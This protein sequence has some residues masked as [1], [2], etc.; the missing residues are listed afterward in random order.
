MKVA[1]LGLG[2]MGAHMARNLA[3][4][5]HDVTVWN[6]TPS[7]AEQLRDHGA[8]VAPSIAQAVPQ[9]DI[10]V[11]MLAD[12]AAVSS[13]AFGADGIICHLKTGAIH[14]SMSTISVALSQQLAAEHQRNGRHYVSAPVFGRPEAASTAK[15][16]VVAAGL[17]IILM[18]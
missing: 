4:A 15:L 17:P 10:V 2:N 6:R 8:H 3:Q 16:F 14:I 11:T 13:A 18:H 7:K 5:K 9:A 12:D 1:F